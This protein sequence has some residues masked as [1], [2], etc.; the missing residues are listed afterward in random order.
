MALASA[1]AAVFS[2]SI[3]SVRESISAFL[4]LRTSSIDFLAS[5]FATASGFTLFTSLVPVDFAWST[6]AFVGALSIASFAASALAFASALAAVFSSSVKSVRESISAF[7]ALRTSSI[8]FLASVFATASGFTLFTSL[9][10]VD[11]AW[12]TAAFVGALSIASFAASALA[13]ASALAAVFSS[14]VKSVRESISSVLALRTSSIDF[15]ASVF[16]TAAGLI[17]VT[18]LVPLVL[19]WSTSAFVVALS[20]AS[21]AASALAFASALAAVFSSSVKSVRDSISSFLALRASSIDFLAFGF[22]TASGFTLFT[23]LVPVD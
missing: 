9:V 3:K 5:V 17:E 16:S 14:S 8:D 4:A 6:A 19:A 10:P 20:M 11:F 1:L 22:A 7:L 2:S 18:S 21:F 15:L 23:S 12:S 13:F